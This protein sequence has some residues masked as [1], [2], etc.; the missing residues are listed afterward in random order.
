MVRGGPLK[1]VKGI[2]Y[3]EKGKAEQAGPADPPADLDRLPFPCREL[4][5]YRNFYSLA[6]DTCATTMITS[7]GCPYRCTYC[8][9][10]RFLGVYRA[11]SA[12]SVTAEIR[13]CLG[14]GI[15]EFYFWDDTFT[16]DRERT[17][18]ICDRIIDEKLDIR[19]SVM[20]RVD[21]VD[22]GL[23][24]RMREAGCTRIRF[25]NESGSQAILDT[26][27]KGITPEQIREAFRGAAEAGVAANSYFMIG[28]P[29]E[30]KKQVRET[31]KLA[32]ELNASF[33]NFSIVTLY[34]GTELYETALARGILKRDCWR[35]F[36]RNPGAD[37][38]PPLWEENFSRQDLIRLQARTYR[39]YYL[40]PSFIIRK[41]REVSTWKGLK[42]IARNAA[43]LFRGR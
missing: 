29:G 1:N 23:M 2:W 15:G 25:G 28:S 6:G 31:L 4:T 36:A 12:A 14:L 16:L 43:R 24:Q 27:K 30:T 8:I 35:E 13:H 42:E 3:K 33:T 11:R 20:T 21:R 10:S 40:R 39:S 17:M 22:R 37:F 7:R 32:K 41:L 5:P 38:Q 18:E 19:W 9:R 34:P 26:L